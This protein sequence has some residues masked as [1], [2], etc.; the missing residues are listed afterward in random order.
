MD[1][2]T[3]DILETANSFWPLVSGVAVTLYGGVRLMLYRRKERHDKE[4]VL[5]QR[6]TN[7]EANTVTHTELD[8]CKGDLSMCIERMEERFN[9]TNKTDHTRIEDKLDRMEKTMTDRLITH[10]DSRK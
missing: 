4:Q 6:L 2:H 5:H 3:K 7:L 1:S 8:V 10:I 9:K